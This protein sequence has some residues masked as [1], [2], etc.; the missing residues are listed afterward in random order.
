MCR[1]RIR[2]VLGLDRAPEVRTLREII[3]GVSST[4]TRIEWMKEL[5]NTRKLVQG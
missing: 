3:A 4:A 5:F 2:E 1:P